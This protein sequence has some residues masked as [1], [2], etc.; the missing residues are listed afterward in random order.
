[1]LVLLSC[2]A[3]LFL[4]LTGAPIVATG[5]V[6]LGVVLQ[7]VLV[8][9]LARATVG[10]VGGHAEWVRDVSRRP[11]LRSDPLWLAAT[12]LVVAGLLLAWL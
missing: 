5:L 1:M 11:R 4:L 12:G 6:G 8:A 3:L 7:L 10:G 9:R 2:T